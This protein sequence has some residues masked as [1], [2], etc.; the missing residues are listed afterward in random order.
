MLKLVPTKF[1]AWL[2]LVV[3]CALTTAN[4]SR[5]A[6]AADCGTSTS[7]ASQ[8]TAASAGCDGHDCPGTPQDQH[9]Q[10][11]ACD[12]CDS[13]GCHASVFSRVSL[14]VRTSFVI[15]TGRREPFR[16]CPEVYL[17]LFVPPQIH[18]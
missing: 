16:L 3:V 17:S 15:V 2:L 14:P 5:S 13:C 10:G 11:D 7:V 18:A 8:V 4:L 6:H 1:L 9:D 12:S